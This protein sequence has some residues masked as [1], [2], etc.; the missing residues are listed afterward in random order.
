MKKNIYWVLIL[1][2]CIILVLL[3]TCSSDKH[4]AK[5]VSL[6]RADTCAVCGMIVVDYFGPHVQIIWNDGKRSV[7]GDLHEAMPQLLNPIEAK[8][9][10]AI[11]VQNFDNLKWGSYKGHWMLAKNAFFVINSRKKSAM[12]VSYVPF[13]KIENAKN[14]QKQN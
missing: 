13:Q 5:A 11:Y 7:Y 3:K 8:R 4:V 10:T 1:L 6:T 14:F 2:I 12:G 9:A